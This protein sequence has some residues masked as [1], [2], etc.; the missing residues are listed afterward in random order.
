MTQEPTPLDQWMTLILQNSRDGINI[1]T[2]DLATGR[3]RLVLC[4]DAF[5]EMSGRARQQLMDAPDL[6]EFV[7]LGSPGGTEHPRLVAAGQSFGGIASWIRPD[8]RENWYEYKA[9]PVTVD[10]RHYLIGIDRDITEQRRVAQGLAQAEAALS[11]M[12][13]ASQERVFLLDARSVV[14]VAN[15]AGARSFGMTPQQIIGRCLYDMVDADAAR[16][17]RQVIGEVIRSGIPRQISDERD[18]VSLQ[19]SIY[20]IRDADGQVTRLA[21]FATDVTQQSRSRQAL[22]E[23]QQRFRSLFEQA[24]IAIFECDLTT[25][26]STILRANRKAS[27][28]Y[29][30]SQEQFVGMPATALMPESFHQ[31]HLQTVNDM[32]DGRSV[33][34][35]GDGVRADGSIFHVRVCAGVIPGMNRSIVMIENVTELSQAQQQLQRAN[36]QL[37]NIFDNSADI[38]FEVDAQGRYTLGNP[39]VKTITGYDVQE[40]IGRSLFELVAPEYHEAFRLR[41]KRR[42]AGLPVEQPFQYEVIAK[43]GR[44]VTVEMVTS[45][46]LRD[47]RLVAIQGVV[48]DVTQRLAM[49]QVIHENEKRYRQVVEHM[50]DGIWIIDP[51]GLTT[52]VN[53][54]MAAMLGYSVQEMMGRP[55]FDFM[56]EAGRKICL[57]KLDM[58]R[59][60]VKE[61]HDFEFICKAGRRIHTSLGTSPIMDEQGNFAGAVAVVE[62]VTSA[63]Q[64]QLAL[65]RSE[66]RYRGV[67]ESQAELVVRVDPQGRFTFVNDA[68]CRTFGKARDELLGQ[69]FAPLVHP[70]DL[71]AA[72]EAMAKLSDPP[73]R[74]IVQQRAMTAGGWRWIEWEDYAIRDGAGNIIEVQ[75]VGRDITRR[76]V[77]LE[78]LKKSEQRYR[79]IVEDQ[80]ELICRFT[81]EGKLTFANQACMSYFNIQPP[82]P[83]G[84]ACFCKF[85][86]ESERGMCH[87]AL[88]AI[89]QQDPFRNVEHRAYRTG[90]IRWLQWTYRALYD[91]LGRFVEFQAVGRDITSRQLAQE[92]LQALHAQLMTARED[93]RKRLARELHDSL[94]QQ[95]IA[96]SYS[97]LSAVS[98][99]EP[100][101]AQRAARN[102]QLQAISDRCTQMVQDIRGICHGLYPPTLESL[103]LPGSLRQIAADFRG[104]ADVSVEVAA[105]IADRRY[106]EEIEIALFRVSQE[107]VCNAIRHGQASV[108]VLE[109]SQQDGRLVL[110]VQDNGRGFDTAAVSAGLGLQTMRER[111]KAIG[112]RLDLASTPGRTR[113][114]VT[115][116]LSVTG[117]DP[118]AD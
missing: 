102:E 116:P 13:N 103:G 24:P 18:G 42:L 98:Q 95:M 117:S 72:M 82:P 90:Q 60:G 59:A 26:P 110:A 57:E 56:D 27:E 40:M 14:L 92:A 25:S 54:Q 74:V 67:V 8:G 43:D 34:R 84:G 64:T 97:I 30:Y 85:A 63:R 20:P 101:A 28:I 36:E 21:T 104:H 107:A 112:G 37:Q 115:V 96:M 111:A 15:E 51:Q 17:R 91:G 118:R 48:R 35:E 23:G 32:R 22:E 73:H 5:V 76:K 29:G 105:A 39:A 93:E 55:V 49:E 41:M 100:D 83:E 66:E 10:G 80:T 62:D 69:S 16:W 1:T 6:N 75:A 108:I 46:V 9:T 94:G 70:D 58:R 50:N 19:V 44:R 52:Y 68:Y 78:E 81:R 65:A 88:A 47:G 31:M 86:I 99:P 79:A 11:A 33:T 7:Q 77:A 38:I 45:D 3:R 114:I 4:N 53:D 2:M 106:K 87:A 113:V 89:S 71:P 12:I 109:L 61:R